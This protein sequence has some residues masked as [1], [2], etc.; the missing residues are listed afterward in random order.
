M[1]LRQYCEQQGL[2]LEKTVQKLHEKGF[3][4]EPDM[5][6][7]EIA[8]TGGVHPSVMRDLLAQ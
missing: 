8:A 1:T 5:T 7:R 2:D 4:A 3:K 6:V